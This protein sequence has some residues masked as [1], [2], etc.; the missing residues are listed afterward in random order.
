MRVSI[1]KTLAV[2]K[3]KGVYRRLVVYLRPYR[4]SFA[5]ALFCMVI[6]GASDGVVPFLVKSVLDGVFQEKREEYLYLFPIALF[7]FALLRGAADFGQQFLMSRIGHFVVRDLRNDLNRHL[8]QMSPGYFVQQRS[9]DLLSRV[10]GDVLLLRSVLTES[11][12]AIIRDSV[13]IVALLC[14]A[15]YLDPL[16]ALLAFVIFPIAIFPVLRFG[17]R[18]RKLSRQGQEGVGSLSA[19]LQESMQGNRVVKIFGR[20]EYE[21]RR[22]QHENDALTHTFVRS[23]RVRALTGPLNEILGSMAIG[24]V[25]L[26]GGLSVISGV[27]SQGDFIAFLLSVFLLY[28]PFKKLSKLHNSMQQGLGSAERVFE[29]LDTK[30]E[31]FEPALPVSLGAKQQIEFIDVG[32]SYPGTESPALQ[33]ISLKIEEGARIALVG[34]SGSG[35]STLIDLIPRFIDA[36]QGSVLVAGVDV[37]KASLAELRA[38]IAMV[39]QHTFLFNDTI[40][41]NIAYGNPSTSRQEVE[42]AARAAYAY[43]FI[44]KLPLG[45]ETKVG[46]GGFALSGG[47]RQR[48]AIARAILKDAPIL[49]LDEATASLDNQAE[50]EV[51]SAIEVLERNRTSVVIAHRLSTVRTADVI[52]VM[53]HGCIVEVGKHEALLANA[54]GEYARLYALQF[55]KQDSQIS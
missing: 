38:R 50:R 11:V 22:F 27:R 35:K 4:G 24:G 10:N 14:A 25:I 49:I 41:A 17:K 53:R 32:F 44:A 55:A 21:D 20:E 2:A 6:F 15:L 48:L 52:V 34:L 30:P 3:Q 37:R 1:T 43:D 40:Y 31:I 8:L 29:V 33:N 46:E 16:L 54:E 47:E 19:M 26:Y 12:A 42:R 23:E 39:G 45:F 7:A 5:L 36:Q 9:A 51:Q 13:R 28:D 18:L